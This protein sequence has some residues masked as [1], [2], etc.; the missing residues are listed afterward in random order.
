MRLMI[1]H[2]SLLT[3]GSQDTINVGDVYKCSDVYAGK[4]FS[5][6]AQIVNQVPS[7][8]TLTRHDPE[9]IQLV[10]ESVGDDDVPI[11][12][13]K[14]DPWVLRES[15]A[16]S[17]QDGRDIFLLGDNVYR[18]TPAFGTEAESLGM[19]MNQQYVFNGIYFEDEVPRPVFACDP[20]INSEV[21]TYPGSR[22]LHSTIDLAG[23]GA[24]TL[25]TGHGGAAWKEAAVN[26]SEQLGVPVK[27]YGIGWGLDYQ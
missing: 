20:V 6:V 18:H 12:I 27:A 23:F 9:L 7:Y 8:K 5:N 1:G 17:F 25:L 22:L 11:R 24:F 14:I 19:Q 16:K 15:V 26:M 3:P 13:T 4:T 10:R 21:T 2:K